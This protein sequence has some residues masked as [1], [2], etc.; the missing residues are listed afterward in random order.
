MQN[1]DIA[2]LVVFHRKK[3]GSTQ[4]E[5]AEIAGVSRFI[6]QEIEAGRDRTRWKHM[7]SVLESLNLKLEPKGPL[8]D[9]WRKLREAS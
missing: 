6:V 4:V 3:A 7:L 9:Q 1:K 5:L 2:S 8:V